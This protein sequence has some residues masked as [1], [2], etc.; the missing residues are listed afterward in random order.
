MPLAL[1]D[2]VRRLNGQRRPVHVTSTSAPCGRVTHPQ[3][4]D[5]HAPGYSFHLFLIVAMR[6]A[7]CVAAGAV[8]V[9]RV[10]RDLLGPGYTVAF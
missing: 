1:T 8:V 10:A 2:V 7:G 5:P 6:R 9:D 4:V 3:C